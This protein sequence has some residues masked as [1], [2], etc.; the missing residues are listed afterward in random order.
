MSYIGTCD[1]ELMDKID[2]AV[3]IA[4]DIVPKDK[5]GTHFITVEQPTIDIIDT[6]EE[7][8]AKVGRKT[9]TLT[10]KQ[11]F[12]NDYE[13]HDVDYMLKKY[14]IKDKKNL[15]QKVYLYRKAIKENFNG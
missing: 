3:S 2:F 6:D 1:K 7:I 13:N 14:K 12:I 4:L 15:Q 10:D 5:I 9:M 8:N 11:R